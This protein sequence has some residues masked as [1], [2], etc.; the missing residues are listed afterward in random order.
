MIS[1]ELI[2]YSFV[3]LYRPVGRVLDIVSVQHEL[4]PGDLLG[5]VSEGP[6]SPG[7]PAGLGL[8]S[9]PRVC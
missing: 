4:Q 7:A 6:A 5:L 2:N 8:R 1:G 3:A 9:L